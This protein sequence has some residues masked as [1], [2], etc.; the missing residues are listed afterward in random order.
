MSLK[1]LPGDDR[2]PSSALSV[3]RTESGETYIFYFDLHGNICYLKGSGAGS[4]GEYSVP[5]KNDGASTTAVGS[6]NTLTSTLFE[7][8]QVHVYYVQDDQL[9][10][11]WWH[12]HDGE[13]KTGL[14]NEMEYKVAPGTGIS[15]LGQ[16]ELHGK[17]GDHRLE[18]YFHDHDNSDKF[19][20]AYYKDKE[21]HKALVQV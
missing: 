18:V 4:Y 10:A 14:I 13:W 3:T 6:I 11:A 20:V 19:S 12:V 2:H 16:Q 7:K 8:E 5:I 1:P 15:S 21:W 17:P 9:K